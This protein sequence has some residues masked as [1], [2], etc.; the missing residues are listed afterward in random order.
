MKDEQFFVGKAAA[1]S[2]M[3]PLGRWNVHV[4]YRRHKVRKLVFRPKRPRQEV[5]QCW[6]VRCQGCFRPFPKICLSKTISEAINRHKPK[7]W[8]VGTTHCR[9]NIDVR[10]LQRDFSVSAL[11]FAKE[12]DAHP[13][14]ACLLCG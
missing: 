9:K 14:D 11:H 5:C 2:L 8:R 3:M 13:D 10:I 4:L 12:C 6:G 1:S 7:V